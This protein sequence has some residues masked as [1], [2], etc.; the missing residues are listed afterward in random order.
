MNRRVKAFWIPGLVILILS[1]GLWPVLRWAF[2]MGLQFEISLRRLFA[3]VYP[4][5]LLSLAA[6]GALCAYW[7]RS[8]GG[9]VG[10][11]LVAALFPVF[12]QFVILSARLVVTLPRTAPRHWA[13]LFSGLLTWVLV[14]ALAAVMGSLPF[15]RRTSAMPG[16]AAGG[17]V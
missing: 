7:S 17:R 6:L 12:V 16:P 11:R 4:R 2:P 9:R 5:W 15:L 13:D 14:P 1:L 10:E 8:A 3:L